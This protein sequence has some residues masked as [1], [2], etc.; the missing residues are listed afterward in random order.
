MPEI[1]V[2]PCI[3]VTWTRNTSF[4]VH[5]ASPVFPIYGL[6]TTTMWSPALFKSA[7]YFKAFPDPFVSLLLSS[8]LATIHK[9]EIFFLQMTAMHRSNSKNRGKSALVLL[10]SFIFFL[11]LSLSLSLSLDSVQRVPTSK[12]LLAARP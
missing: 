8:R 6:V 2:V 5:V 12:I 1:E 9:L 11:L 7:K 10:L 3:P 4:H